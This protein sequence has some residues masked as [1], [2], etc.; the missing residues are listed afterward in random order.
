ISTESKNEGDRDVLTVNN[1]TGRT[2]VLNR[3]KALNSLTTEMVEAIT[4]HLKEWRQSDLCDVVIIRSNL[5]KAFCAGGDVVKASKNWQS[6]DRGK[7]MGF[8][9]KE[10]Q[11]NHLV[12]SY[13]KPL[14]ALINGYVMGGGV[15]LSVHAPFRVATEKS[16]FSM[17]ETRIGF[18]PD[19][20]ATFFLPRMDG[21]T[22]VYLG[23][24]GQWLR[25]RDLLYAGIATHYVPSERLPLLEK[26][27][28]E[29]GT[30]DHMVVNQAIE[31]FAAQAEAPGTIEYSL[32][33]KREAVDRCFRYNKMETIVEALRQETEQREWAQET[34]E[35]LGRMSP[36]S[37]KLTLEQLRNGP[38]LNIQQALLLELR[39]AEKRFESADMHEGI[40]E[41]LISKTNKPQWSPATLEAVDMNELHAE[42]FESSGKYSVVDFIDPM[43]AFDEYPHKFGLPSEKDIADVVTGANPQVGSF[44]LKHEDVLGFFDRQFMS[45]VGVEQKVSWV[46]ERKT[47]KDK[48][49][50]VLRWIK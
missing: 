13:E 47:V 9:Q 26:R 15:G 16:V 40:G 30:R 7:A 4:R 29:L 45:K 22:G 42:Y 14:V 27:L 36:S 28:Q 33:D 31:E 44:G 37:L 6:G 10:Y 20:G 34:L 11:M 32:A 50:F 43:V 49:S 35:T 38:R 23:L 2:L 8:L 39:M 5:D 1:Q 48:D 21:Q 12:A 46:L 24:T 41:L 19:V 3:P 18:F 17:P 25:G